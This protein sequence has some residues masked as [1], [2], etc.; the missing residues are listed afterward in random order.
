[1][2][3][4]FNGIIKVGNIA[5]EDSVATIVVDRIVQGDDLFEEACL[6]HT[7]SEE[8]LS[9]GNPFAMEDAM[10][11][12]I[13][14]EIVRGVLPGDEVIVSGVIDYDQDMVY[15]VEVQALTVNTIQDYDITVEDEDELFVDYEESD[16]D[17]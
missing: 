8:D 3:D 16:K 7:P 11:F 15:D 10:V 14:Q 6:Y 4:R 12:E 9:Q 5:F 13:S 2:I 17:E 1:M